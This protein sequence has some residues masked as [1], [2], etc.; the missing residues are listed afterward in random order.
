L[1]KVF[2]KEHE[3]ILKKEFG[4][5]AT[6]EIK[7]IFCHF[8][9]LNPTELF[10]WLEEK[11][12]GAQSIEKI[13]NAVARRLQLEPLQ[14]ILGSTSFRGHKILVGPGV[15]IP[16]PETEILVD[17]LRSHLIGKK[18]WLGFEYGFGSGAISIALLK[19][20][21]GGRI[22]A[23]EPHS[24][25]LHWGNQNIQL[26]H[27]ESKIDLREMAGFPDPSQKY[28]FIVSNPPY[29]E[30]EDEK[31]MQ[32][33]VKDHEPQEALFVPKG[34]PL[35]HYEIILLAAAHQLNENGFIAMEIDPRFAKKIKDLFE[36]NG[37]SVKLENDLL[38]RQRIMLASL[39]ERSGGP[40]GSI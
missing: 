32:V 29:L 39:L 28:D 16:R 31:T 30:I 1:N 13:K 9:N 21:P 17:I 3:T 40:N 35:Y 4:H 22:V 36:G 19:E 26:H 34:C 37:F 20:N 12:S 27:L 8:L 6:Q 23:S 33:E 18:N 14:Y 5:Q 24:L 10:H 7:W 25:A 11:S 38:N 2:Y 15:L